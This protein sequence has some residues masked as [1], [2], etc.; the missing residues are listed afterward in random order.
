MDQDDEVEI[1]AFAVDKTQ[2]GL[3][4]IVTNSHGFKILEEYLSLYASDASEQDQ[5]NPYIQ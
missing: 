2:D 1:P 5:K 4:H 3:Y